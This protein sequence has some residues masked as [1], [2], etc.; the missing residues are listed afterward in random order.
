MVRKDI[1]TQNRK[2]AGDF[3]MPE[4]LLYCPIA[5]SVVPTGERFCTQGKST[6]RAIRN[7]SKKLTSEWGNERMSARENKPS[8][9]GLQASFLKIF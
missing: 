2:L 5:R 8:T 3:G 7:Y 6:G 9:N 4:K 1:R